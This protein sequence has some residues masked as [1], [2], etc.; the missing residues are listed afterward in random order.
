MLVY[1][2]SITNGFGTAYEDVYWSKMQRLMN[3]FYDKPLKIIPLSN[4]GHSAKDIFIAFQALVPKAKIETNIEAILYQ[5]NQNDITPHGNKDIKRFWK[6]NLKYHP[7]QRAFGRFRYKYLHRSVF[8]NM[9]FSNVR[10]FLHDRSGTCE[11]RGIDALGSYSWTFGSRKFKEE[12]E[13][14]WKEFSETLGKMKKKSQK[15]GAD[16]LIFYTPTLF[17]IDK[18][19]VHD[20]YNGLNLD[21]SCATIQ[22]KERLKSIAEKFDIDIIDPSDYVRESFENRLKEGNFSSYFFLDDTNHFTAVAA[23]YIA[24][25]LAAHFIKKNSGGRS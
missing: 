20:R 3:L 18:R 14:L 24:E 21:F 15:L 17:D 7:L 23:D 22:P 19:G 25:Y 4:Q 16:F 12:S 10:L 1:G 11:E 8:F 5:F 9:V 13:N 2:D 6:K